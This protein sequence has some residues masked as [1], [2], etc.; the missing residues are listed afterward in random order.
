MTEI[1]DLIP[2]AEEQE[3]EDM[4]SPAES[5]EAKKD[6]FTPT[7]EQQAAIKQL[8][9]YDRMMKMVQAKRGYE[10]DIEVPAKVKA[11]RRAKNKVARA[12][13]KRNRKTA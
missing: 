1:K 3:L 10:K 12:A 7:P 5:K 9:T 13:R 11:K 4:V 2:V 6:L 8:L